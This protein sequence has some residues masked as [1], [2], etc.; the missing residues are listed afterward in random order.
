KGYLGWL[1]QAKR[2]ETRLKRIQEIIQLCQSG[3]KSRQS[4]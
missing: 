2:A 4:Y 1:F 3:I